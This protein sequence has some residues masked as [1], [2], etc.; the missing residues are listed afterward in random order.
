ME[1]SGDKYIIRNSDR[2]TFKTCRMKWHWSSPLR[3]NLRPI[4]GSKPFEFGTTWHAGMAVLYD[5]TTWHLRMSKDSMQREFVYELV[6]K[7]FLDETEKQRKQYEED[8]SVELEQDF[9]ERRKL[10]I[11]MLNNYFDW[12]YRADQNFKPVKIEVGFE[13]PILHPI[14][15][16]QLVIDDK[17]VVY[18]GR[19]DG[20]VQDRAGWYWILEHK[21]T[22][23]F[24]D[25]NHLA[26]DEQLTSYGWALRE[27]GISVR[28]AIY[29]E[30]FK[31]IPEPVQKNLSP[32]KGRWLSVNKMQRVTLEQYMSAITAEGEDPEL[33][34]EFLDFLSQQGNPFFRRFEEHR[35]QTEYDM[36][37]A[38]IYEEA[39]DMLDSPRIYPTP[40]KFNCSYCA[41]REPC[42]ARM[43][44]QDADFL[45]KNLFTKEANTRDETAVQVEAD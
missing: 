20:I 27:L 40:G 41:F 11:G 10:G 18:Q 38:Q 24:G 29:S 17:P 13:V 21:T 6:R 33:Y 2:R 7:A 14:Q 36:I 15:K 34:R 39:I 3:A 42:L 35:T 4:K 37:G 44:G 9:V 19:L 8:M 12:S 25:M 5:P 16:T 43:Q 45:L 31:A 22:S 32:R 26:L 1:T 30:A 23:Q 28:G